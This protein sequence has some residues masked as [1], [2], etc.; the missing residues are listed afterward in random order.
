MKILDVNVLLFCSDET[1]EFHARNKAFVTAAIERDEAIALPWLVVLAFLRINTRRIGG[2]AA[3]TREQAFATIDTWLAHPNV[4]VLSPGPR[5]YEILREL[6][7]EALAQGDLVMDAHL[8][9]LAIEN[10]AELVSTDDDFS[11]FPRVKWT[12]PANIV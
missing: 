11:R 4:S 6:A 8:A 7:D 2:R 10:G 12:N 1:S 9:A 5:H 3:M